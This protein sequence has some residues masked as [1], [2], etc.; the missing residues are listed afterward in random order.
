MDGE[1]ERSDLTAR[2]ALWWQRD[3]EEHLLKLEEVLNRTPPDEEEM[4]ILRRVAGEFRETEEA[5]RRLE[6]SGY[7]PGTIF[8]REAQTARDLLREKEG[9]LERHL[10]C[11]EQQREK[12]EGTNGTEKEQRN[13]EGECRRG[14]PRRTGTR[15]GAETGRR[16]DEEQLYGELHQARGEM[17]RLL[18]S[19][20]R[21]YRSLHAAR[22]K[23][24][25]LATT[26]ATLDYSFQ[27][28][29]NATLLL[30]ETKYKEAR[31]A[32]QKR[33]R[34]RALLGIMVA[35]GSVTFSMGAL[36]HLAYQRQGAELASLRERLTATESVQ[37]AMSAGRKELEALITRGGVPRREEEG[38]GWKQE[39]KTAEETEPA[40][41][42]RQA[43][44]ESPPARTNAAQLERQVPARTTEHGT[45][46]LLYIV[47]RGDTLCSLRR[48]YYDDETWRAILEA[49]HG[50]IV[51]PEAWLFPGQPIVMPEGMTATAGLERVTLGGAEAAAYWR[52]GRFPRR[53]YQTPVDT[54]FEE[55][56][57]RLTGNAG[58]ASQI[59]EAYGGVNRRL[60]GAPRRND[61]IHIPPSIPVRTT[62]LF[63]GG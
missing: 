2:I 18:P 21:T 52:T 13:G 56:S 25:D 41:M 57:E 58:Y 8:Y 39:S 37:G 19:D 26:A 42:Q 47:E 50:L 17:E 51:H 6:A 22:D 30:A 16:R 34:N 59:K 53:L 60:G 12:E 44:V 28:E 35:V 32:Y 14:T 36:R 63:G 4:A 23:I 7:D 33:V 62:L 10:A 5:L 15:E 46:Q 1:K 3:G 48:R 24:L 29:A 20:P 11:L 45:T 61:F 40:P 31:Q 54:T 27:D 9:A 49:N 43:R 55:I 38:N